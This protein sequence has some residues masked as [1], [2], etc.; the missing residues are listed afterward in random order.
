MASMSAMQKMK[1]VKELQSAG[2]GE[3]GSMIP[4]M[5]GLGFKTK[6]S[7]H[8]TSVKDRFKKRKR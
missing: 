2:G 6:G 8:T 5:S 1:A 4:G 3:G 7:T